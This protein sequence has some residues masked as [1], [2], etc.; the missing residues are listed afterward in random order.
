MA[1]E[2]KSYDD[3]TI[4]ELVSLKRRLH[5]KMIELVFEA[6]EM[7]EQINDADAAWN[8]AC[9]PRAESVRNESK[10]VLEI[11][12]VLRNRI[13][14]EIG[15]YPRFSHKLTNRRRT[16]MIQEIVK[17]H[18]R[19][20]EMPSSTRRTLPMIDG[21]RRSTLQV[22]K[23]RNVYDGI[24][25][26]IRLI[27]VVT[28]HYKSKYAFAMDWADCMFSFTLHEWALLIILFAEKQVSVTSGW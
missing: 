23:S 12:G 17:H 18:L 26:K 15:L 11:S 10:R 21:V 7:M 20:C 2:N 1:D 5:Q 19:E 3:F 14:S 4:L 24:H 22:V 25:G 13:R 28:L 27:F 6:C 16:L 9:A 8:I